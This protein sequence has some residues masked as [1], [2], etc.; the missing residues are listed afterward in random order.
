MQMASED[1]WTA[2]WAA[3]KL[4][5]FDD[6]D[7]TTILGPG[8][9]KVERRDLPKIIIATLCVYNLDIDTLRRTYDSEPSPDFVLNL[10]SGAALTAEALHLSLEEKVPVGF[11]GDL[12]RA[13]SMIDVRDYVDPETKFRERGLRQH[14]RVASFVR[15]DFRRYR[16]ERIGLPSKIVIFLNDYDLVAESIRHARSEYGGFDIV[17]STNPNAR[18]T[19]TAVEVANHMGCGVFKWGNFMSILHQ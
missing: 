6:V 15:L 3:K 9:L 2:S 1:D 7:K 19:E 13:L 16:I 12:M 11:M 17:V 10:Q 8:R 4:S 14:S 5:E 18:I